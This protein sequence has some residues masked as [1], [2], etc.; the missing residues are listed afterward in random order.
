MGG[1]LWVM[2]KQPTTSKPLLTASHVGRRWDYHPSTVVR[3]MQRFG[4]SGL[5]FG[6]SRQSARRFSEEDVQKVEELAGFGK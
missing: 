4:F 6:S 2:K 5:K 1:V 3:V